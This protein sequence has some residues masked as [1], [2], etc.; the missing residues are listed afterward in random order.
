MK[1]SSS[2]RGFLAA[3]LALAA[4]SSA[5]AA[6]PKLTY[7]T[8][9]KTGLKVTALS[10][11][12]M[13]TTDA[14]VIERAADT[15]IVHFDTAR[16]YQ[17]GNNE[18]MVGAALKSRRAKVV[19]SSKSGGKT[20]QAALADLDTSLRELGTDYLDIWYLHM[21]NDPAEVTE[22]LLEAQRAA[23]KAGK[24]SASPGS[25]RTSI[26]TACC[27]TWPN[28][29]RPTSSSPPTTS[30]CALSRPAPTQTPQRQRQT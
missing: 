23:K 27:L 29:A 12:C 10:F 26:W 20:A 30:P 11:G 17:N 2:R 1:H 21:K 28:S 16:S 4:S 22:E 15:G 24:R 19:I 3:P 9:G 5:P 6:E 18:R 25:V 13:T 14:S 8:L 7:R